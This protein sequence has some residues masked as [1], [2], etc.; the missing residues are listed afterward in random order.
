MLYVI[1]KNS[2]IVY[3][4]Q[5]EQLTEEKWKKTCAQHAQKI[6]EEHS[7]FY[8]LLAYWRDIEHESITMQ[9]L[10]IKDEDEEY[11]MNILIH[12]ICPI[13]NILENRNEKQI[14]L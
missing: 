5:I 2:E 6:K 1:K 8:S 7:E 14:K 3:V 9:P 10:D 12:V 11:I 13:G 4:G